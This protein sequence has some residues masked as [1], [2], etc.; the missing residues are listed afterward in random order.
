MPEQQ[1][2]ALTPRTADRVRQLVQDGGSVGGPGRSGSAARGVT[3]VKVTGGPDGDGWHPAVVSLDLDGEWSDLSAAVALRADDETPLTTGNR[4]PCTRTGD[5]A[6]GVARFR[7]RQ[8]R[9]FVKGTLAAALTVGGSVTLNLVGWNG[10]SEAT[11]GETLTVHD[12]FLTGSQTIASGTKVG[13]AL[14]GGR[15]Y[16]TTG[17]C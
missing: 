13:A 4:Y 3:W 5:D 2:Y 1:L 10:S 6:D 8:P 15:W 12:Y 17:S 11:T 14:D 16:V 9:Q 7:A